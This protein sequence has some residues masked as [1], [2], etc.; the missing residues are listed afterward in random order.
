MARSDSGV[1]SNLAT[2]VSFRLSDDS[3]TTFGIGVF[4][5]VGAGVNYAGSQTTPILTPRQ[6][7][8]YFGVGPIAASTSFLA[9]MP[10]ASRQFTDRLAIGGGPMIVTGPASFNPAFFAPGPRDALGLP[11]FPSA[12]NSRPF[13]G[14][15]FQLGMLYNLSDSWNLG[16]SYKS[17]IWQE[18]YGFN[19]SYPDLAARR[20]GI[21]AQVPEIFSWGI[22]YK[23]FE[24]ALID[25]DLRY[26]DYK[27]TT[28][29]GTKPIDGGLGWSSI[30]AVA[31]GGQYQATEKLTLR[32]GYLYNTNPIKATDTLF[33][34][35][36]PGFLQ[37]MLALGVSYKLTD[38]IVLTAAWTHQFRNAIEGP[39]LQVQAP[40]ERIKLDAQTDSIVLGLNVQFGAPRKPAGLNSTGA[41][42]ID[43]S[44]MLP[45]PRSSRRAS[46]L[47]QVSEP[48]TF[49]TCR[50]PMTPS[51]AAGS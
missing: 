18:R 4:G 49:L 14:A 51:S 28:L 47:P 27:N 16:F 9:I 41:P 33:N 5:L 11:T 31:V 10:S 48:R 21:Q 24:R 7:P 17:P 45:R 26:F 25:V 38:D 36:A 20:I 12:T 6:P 39:I 8:N 35:Q 43:G 29:Y 19:S 13:W 30:F 22:A 3:P 32:A 15:G 2:G 1:A 37:Q 40:G 50:P 34:V 23:G 42:V 46:I 44:T